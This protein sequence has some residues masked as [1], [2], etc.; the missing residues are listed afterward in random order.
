[1]LTFLPNA[2]LSTRRRAAGRL[3]GID[4]CRRLDDTDVTVQARPAQ[5][6]PVHPASEPRRRDPHDPRGRTPA[7]PGPRPTT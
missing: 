4:P 1:M 6:R 2:A 7:T 5:P 3:G